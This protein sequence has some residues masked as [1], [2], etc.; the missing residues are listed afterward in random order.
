MAA[1]TVI[2]VATSVMALV[3]FLALVAMAI[4]LV[5]LASAVRALQGELLQLRQDL[6]ATVHDVRQMT[7]DAAAV[8]HGGR[9]LAEKAGS[10]LTLLALGRAFGGGGG[11]GLW[12]VLGQAAAGALAPLVGRLVSRRLG[13]DE[14]GSP[15]PGRPGEPRP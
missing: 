6:L 9:R 11:S 3:L 14:A 5:R 8:V 10:A 12:A 2:A 7:D 1:L 13:G 15:A 4:L